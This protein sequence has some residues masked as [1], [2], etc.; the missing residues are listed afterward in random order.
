MELRRKFGLVNVGEQ[1]KG[2]NCKWLGGLWV[3]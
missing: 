3:Y 1:V 2:A